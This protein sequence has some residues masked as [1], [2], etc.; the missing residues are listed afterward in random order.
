MEFIENLIKIGCVC[1]VIAMQG[2]V[3]ER[4]DIVIGTVAKAEAE[5]MVVQIQS[6]I[7]IQNTGAHRTTNKHIFCQGQNNSMFLVNKLQSH[8]N[9]AAILKQ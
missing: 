4:G 8:I 3:V 7:G 9:L 2:G 1:I 5:A 6:K